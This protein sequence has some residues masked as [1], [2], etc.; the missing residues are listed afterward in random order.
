MKFT[1]TVHM[2]NAAFEDAG[3]LP[4]I[5]ADLAKTIRTYP[6]HGTWHVRDI[7]GNH[8]GVAEFKGRRKA[9]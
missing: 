2:D 8:V 9:A 6:E 3:E 5:L 7:N 4:R 1:L